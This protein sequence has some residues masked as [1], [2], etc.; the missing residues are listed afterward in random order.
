MSLLSYTELL[1]LQK[2]GVIKNS[3][4]DH[5]NGSSIDI[6]L[7]PT[8]L[9]EKQDRLI[10][11]VSLRGREPL[12]MREVKLIAPSDEYVLQPGEFILAQSEQVF[13][14]PANLSAEYKL[15]SS[16]GRI[17]LEHMNAGWCDA[18]WHGSVLTLELANLTRYHAIRIKV[19]DFVGQ[20]VF[21]RH[22]AVPEWA[23]YAKRGRYNNDKTVQGVK[24]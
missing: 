13:N 22:T 15:K 1:E 10:R 4:P 3:L 2:R 5:I 14:L 20:V 17:A 19:G 9:V 23:G 24:P 16:M 12:Q 11:T 18:Y 8:I 21:F 6:T 7:G